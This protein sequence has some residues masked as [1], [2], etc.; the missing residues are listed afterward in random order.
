VVR[1]RVA[2]K[3]AFRIAS[4]IR[5]MV[6]ICP[7]G[8]FG[9]SAV[10][11]HLQKY[12]HSRLTQITS[13]TAA[14]R[15]ATISAAARWHRAHQVQRRG[16]NSCRYRCRQK[17]DWSLGCVWHSGLLLWCPAQ[18][19][20]AGGAGARPDHPI[21]GQD[22]PSTTARLRGAFEGAFAHFGCRA[23]WLT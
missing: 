21:N 16:T 23:A 9:S 15:C 8:L 10:Q 5:A 11:P 13:R 20:L 14:V 4:L 1:T 6:L 22:T 17:S 2:K 18:A 19:S 12:F 7:D 3:N